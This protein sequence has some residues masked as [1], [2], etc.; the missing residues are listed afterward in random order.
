MIITVPAIER[1]ENGPRPINLNKD[2]PQVLEL[3]RLA[4]GESL[5]A[6]GRRILQGQTAVTGQ[7]AILY[8]FNPM[9]SRL[10]RGFVWEKDG[11]IIGNVTLLDTKING[12]YLIVI[13][14][15]GL[16]YS[17]LQCFLAHKSSSTWIIIFLWQKTKRHAHIAV[18]D[19]FW[20]AVPPP[21]GNITDSTG[22]YSDPNL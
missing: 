1:S 14:D 11:R 20:T 3:L 15:D 21:L 7:P 10:S 5:D 17:W 4:F 12:R 9:A 6:E 2:I 16:L 22:N 8:R 18:C 19:I 13:K